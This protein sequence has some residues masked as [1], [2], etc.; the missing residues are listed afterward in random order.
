MLP[1]FITFNNVHNFPIPV[2]V[3]KKFLRA[4]WL[5]QKPSIAKINLNGVKSLKVMNEKTIAS[6]KGIRSWNEKYYPVTRDENIKILDDYLT[7]CEE[8]NIRPIMFMAPLTEKYVK[9]FY[10]PLFD[11]FYVLVE[12]TRRKHPSAVFIDGCKWQ[13]VTY[14]DFYDHQHLNVHGAAKFSA[15]LNEF[16]EQLEKQ[17]S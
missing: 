6:D 16:I 2:D 11:E 5:T 4:D 13:G 1:Y 14:D 3:Y 8:N 10:K 15:Y 7:L 9:V 17:G 12:Q